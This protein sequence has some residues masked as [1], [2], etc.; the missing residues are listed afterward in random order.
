MII[1]GAPVGYSARSEFFERDHIKVA[2]KFPFCKIAGAATWNNTN[3]RVF[4]RREAV[5]FKKAAKVF[6]VD[7]NM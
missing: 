4:G 3:H 7:H 1:F 5:S 6:I 2:R